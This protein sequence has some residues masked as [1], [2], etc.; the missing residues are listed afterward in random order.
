MFRTFSVP[1]TLAL[2]IA[3][4]ATTS[5]VGLVVFLTSDAVKAELVTEAAVQ[6][7][8]AKGDRQP[9]QQKGAACS[10]RAWPNYEPRCLF[11]KRR[12]FAEMPAVRFIALRAVRFIVLR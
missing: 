1:S 7:S 2:I 9:V 8:E 12:P 6:Q 3:M 11:D 5:L 4:A 10:S